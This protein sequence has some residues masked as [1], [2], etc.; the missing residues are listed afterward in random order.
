[1]TAINIDMAGVVRADA[2]LTAAAEDAAHAQHK[3]AVYMY[4]PSGTPSFFLYSTFS[5]AFLKSTWVT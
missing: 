3:L 2:R 1:M 4:I 5:F